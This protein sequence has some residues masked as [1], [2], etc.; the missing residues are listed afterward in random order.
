VP[1]GLVKHPNSGPDGLLA[2]V[3]VRDGGGTRLLVRASGQAPRSLAE[4]DGELGRASFSPDG[5]RVAYSDGAGLHVVGIDGGAATAWTTDP[6]D[7]DP[8]WTSDGGLAFTRLGA[9]GVPAASYVASPGAP[10]RTLQPGAQVHDVD[11]AGAAALVGD[12]TALALVPLAGGPATPVRHGAAG[13]AGYLG[14]RLSPDGTWLAILGG[15]DSS[16]FFRVD[17]A[18]GDATVVHR[19]AAGQTAGPPT[20]LSDGR[21]AFRPEIWLGELYLLDG[22][23]ADPART[24]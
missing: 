3:A 4:S 5:A 6:G 11:R 23:W 22:S 18:T 21:I 17:R 13:E 8:V 19:V 20:I 15:V 9:G 7:R 16:T 2:W 24:P 12:G 1:E 10:V 14:A